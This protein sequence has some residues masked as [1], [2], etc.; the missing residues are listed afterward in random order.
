MGCALFVIGFTIKVEQEDSLIRFMFN[1]KLN[2]GS[3]VRR[4]M[5]REI[6]ET[7]VFYCRERGVGGIYASPA[8]RSEI[9]VIGKEENWFTFI[10]RKRMEEKR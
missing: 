9:R 5:N 10:G 8:L 7:D 6:A 4:L 1:E 2:D 3:P